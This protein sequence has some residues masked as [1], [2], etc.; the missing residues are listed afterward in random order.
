MGARLRYARLMALTLRS[1]WYAMGSRWIGLHTQRASTT[2]RNGTLSM[3]GGGYGLAATL[4][5]GCFAH[6]LDR[7]EGRAHVRTMRTRIVDAL[8]VNCHRL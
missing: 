1:G 7:A 4:N 8:L 5:R 2:A 3:Q 6:A